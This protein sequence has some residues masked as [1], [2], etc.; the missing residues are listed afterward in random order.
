PK[1]TTLRGQPNEAPRTDRSVL[2]WTGADTLSMELPL[3]GGET[4]L[5]TVDI[6][7]HGV[8]A[9]PPVCLPYSPEFKPAQS[10]RGLV[11]LERLGRATNGQERVDLPDIWKGLP[12][13]VRL[14][15][16]GHWLLLAAVVLWL[17][18]VLERR[19][20][21]VTGLLATRKAQTAVEVEPAGRARPV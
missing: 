17:A 3:D 4:A 21:L 15:P 5:A 7:G 10:D 6:P 14:I 16:I 13:Q 8:V 9:L 1:V 20:G 11:T 12:R 19:T 2:R 18:E